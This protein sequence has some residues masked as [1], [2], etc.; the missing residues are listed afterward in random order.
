[1]EIKGTHEYENYE[2][3]SSSDNCYDCLFQCKIIVHEKKQISLNCRHPK[4]PGKPEHCIYFK[5]KK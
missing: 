2:I 3:V 1:M 4:G 5:K